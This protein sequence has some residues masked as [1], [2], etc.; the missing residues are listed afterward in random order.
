MLNQLIFILFFSSPFPWNLLSTHNEVFGL[1]DYD[2]DLKSNNACFL[3]S[4]WDLKIKNKKICL[5]TCSLIR[6]ETTF[7]LWKVMEYSIIKSCIYQATYLCIYR[8]RCKCVQR[9]YIHIY[10][11]VGVEYIVWKAHH[12]L[13]CIKRGVASRPGEVIAS[14]GT[15]RPGALSRLYRLTKPGCPVLPKNCVIGVTC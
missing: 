14:S 12:V 3:Y 6:N 4:Y 1:F 9:R 8:E 11:P 2:L 5:P 13:S 15:L 10:I 7:V